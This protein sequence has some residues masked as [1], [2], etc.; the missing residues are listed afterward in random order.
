M[1]WPF[2]PPPLEER[3][4]E[5]LNRKKPGLLE[6][7]ELGKRDPKAVFVY[8]ISAK[9]KEELGSDTSIMFSVLA[10]AMQTLNMIETYELTCD[11]SEALELATCVYYGYGAMIMKEIAGNVDQ[12]SQSSE[13]FMTISNMTFDDLLK[14]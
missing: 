4:K 8:A 5:A 6:S 1:P 14:D 11:P 9:I 7:S 3:I 2:S 10:C 13:R 12:G